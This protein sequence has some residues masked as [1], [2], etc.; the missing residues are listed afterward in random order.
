MW[1]NSILRF[2]QAQCII[3]EHLSKNK[4]VCT[5][6]YDLDTVVGECEPHIR[7]VKI[8]AVLQS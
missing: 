7:A 4:N 2:A 3:I 6:L 5:M 1:R 8:M